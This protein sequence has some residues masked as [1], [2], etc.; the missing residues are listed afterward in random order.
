[1]GIDEYG[2]FL[3]GPHFNLWSEDN[4]LVQR[5]NG[6]DYSPSVMPQRRDGN[7]IRAIVLETIQKSHQ[8]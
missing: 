7:N 6:Q 5:Y 8:L 1:V 3:R 2:P 4:Y